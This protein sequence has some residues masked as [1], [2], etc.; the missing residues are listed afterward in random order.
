MPEATH[1]A[2]RFSAGRRSRDVLL[3]LAAVNKATFE[4]SRKM[5]L[6]PRFAHTPTKVRTHIKSDSNSSSLMCSPRAQS[7]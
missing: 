6:R 4:S 2:R 7:P 5:T 1:A 3:P